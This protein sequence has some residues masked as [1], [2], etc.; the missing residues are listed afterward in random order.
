MMSRL[1]Q[2]IALAILVVVVLAAV[3]AV[4]SIIHKSGAE[5]IAN[6]TSSIHVTLPPA[7]DRLEAELV[8]IKPSGFEPAEITRPQGSVLLAIYNRS[9]LEEVNLRLEVESGPRLR[10]VRVPRKRLD[11]KEIVDLHPGR[12][13]LTELNHPEWNCTITVTAR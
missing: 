13:R 2:H 4:G 11:F 1:Q 9:G 12:Y 3:L 10:E 7:S 8:T 5:P 6:E